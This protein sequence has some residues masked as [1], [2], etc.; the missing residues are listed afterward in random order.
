MT[1]D[2][3]IGLA[4]F[5]IVGGGVVRNLQRNADILARRSG[6]RFHLAR[7]AVRDT[8]RARAVEVD[9]ALITTDPLAL[10][11]DPAISVV[12][13]LMGGTTLAADLIRTA[14]ENGKAVVTA[15]KALLAEQGEALIRLADAQRKPLCFEAS[16]A[17]GIPILKSLR[18]GLVANHITAI[19]GI[20]NGTC[21]FILSAMSQQGMSYADA[22]KEAQAAGFAEADPTLDVEG[23]DAMHKAVILAALAY[24]VWVNPEQVSVTG[25]SRLEKQDFDHAR[26]LGF[27]IKLLAIIKAGAGDAV[28]VR[29]QPTLVPNDHVLAS[30]SGSF[31]ALMVRGDVVGQTLFYGPGAGA[32]ATSSAVISDLVEAAAGLDTGTPVRG[33]LPHHLYRTLAPAGDAVSRYYIRVNVLDQTGVLASLCSILSRHGISLSSVLQPEAQPGSRVPVVFL[34]HEVRSAALQAALAQIQAD[35]L[36]DEPPVALHLETFSS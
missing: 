24:G 35:A 4:G 16:V 22:L 32:D 7:I 19:H 33:I 2:I 31:N 30:V 9:P 13:E 17:G 11:R 5:G 12:V 15:N 3:S 1:R 6:F 26:R 29:V 20:V 25:I 10:A 27:T 23:Y 28:E 14:L 34:T 8:A 18:E 21:N 36:C